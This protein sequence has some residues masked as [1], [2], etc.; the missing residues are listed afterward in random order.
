MS[1]IENSRRAGS[2]VGMACPV[3]K[4]ALLLI[5]CSSVGVDLLPRVVG[6]QCPTLAAQAGGDPTS[7]D[8]SHFSA[9][10]DTSDVA[11]G[12]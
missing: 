6:E 11:A 4:V 9:Y 8:L 1:L 3:G 2:L 7:L 5:V 12:E 10:L